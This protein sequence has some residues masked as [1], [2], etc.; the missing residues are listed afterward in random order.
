MRSC[1]CKGDL[2]GGTFRLDARDFLV[3]ISWPV[4]APLELQPTSLRIATSQELS[5]SQY[6]GSFI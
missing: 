4:H 6:L 3:K 2:L 5:Y 1:W